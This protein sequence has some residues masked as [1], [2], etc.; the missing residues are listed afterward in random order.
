LKET[1]E[2][3]DSN[4]F[5]SFIVLD[6]III[7][8]VF[9]ILGEAL[10]QKNAVPHVSF[11]CRIFDY[12]LANDNNQRDKII[13]FFRGLALCHDTIP[14]RIDGRIKLSSSNP[15]DEVNVST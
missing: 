6:I 15:D 2:L 4:N 9:S 8:L 10:A 12:D 11:F 14:E 3:L 1:V 13:T 7:E 5:N